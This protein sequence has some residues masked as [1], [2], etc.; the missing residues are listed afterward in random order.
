MFL[1]MLEANIRARVRWPAFTQIE[2]TAGQSILLRIFPSDRGLAVFGGIELN[3][4]P[5]RDI[6]DRRQFRQ[7]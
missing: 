2:R 1:F 7:D 3:S 5:F 6:T 4:N